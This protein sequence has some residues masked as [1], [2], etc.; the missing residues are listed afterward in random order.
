MTA[1]G[2]RRRRLAGRIIALLVGSDFRY[3]AW[4]FS[5]PATGGSTGG[6]ILPGLEELL[7]AIPSK[8]PCVRFDLLTTR[9]RSARKKTLL[10]LLRSGSME[11]AIKAVA[12][13][14]GYEA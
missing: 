2:V 13:Y 7:A 14:G 11:A 8:N 9:I 6:A 12:S 4:Q 1:E 10:D 3:P 5:E